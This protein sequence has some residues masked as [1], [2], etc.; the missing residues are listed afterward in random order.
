MKRLFQNYKKFLLFVLLLISRNYTY[1]QAAIQQFWILNQSPETLIWDN[2]G[3]NGQIDNGSGNWNTTETNWT[4]NGGKI[5]TK[6]V[7][8]KNAVFGGNPGVA[9][10]G[11]VTLLN[12]VSVK[13][14]YFK[15]VS[16]GNFILTGSSINSCFSP[17]IISTEINATIASQLTGINPI[18]KTDAGTLTLTGNNT[19]TGSTVVNGGILQCGDG[20]TNNGLSVNTSNININSGST[21]YL[22]YATAVNLSSSNYGPKITGN[23]I[24]RLNS[25]QA[26]N[27]TA[28]WGG[29]ST[30]F[31]SGFTGTLQ[32]DNGRIDGQVP[33]L[34]GIK[35][36]VINENGQFM[37]RTGI[38]S[39]NFSINGNGW[40]ETNY[41][42]AL[43]AA[44]SASPIFTGTITLT[45]DA[46]L[47]IQNSNSSMELQ[48]NIITNGY[49]LGGMIG[50]I[51]GNGGKLILN[52]KNN[53]TFAGILSS[54]GSLTLNG[55]SIITLTG[56]NTYSGGTIINAGTAVAG[57]VN[58]FG[59]GTITVNSGA[60]ISKN[61]FAIAN[62]IINNGGSVLP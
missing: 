12:V 26:V 25:A 57:N 61:G 43:R 45:G 60:T 28:D 2:N 10:A 62:T 37:A 4:G 59:T 8:C 52:T 15:S 36:I 11:I 22:N 29:G 33:G 34:S 16:N 23:G 31:G 18:L 9:V 14:L 48:G 42:G 58:A 20:T 41:T 51:G 5:N 50:G 39:Q 55:S 19:Y 56:N 1:S 47:F 46:N 54:Q 7:S 53:V 44:G 6:W 49:S 38:F 13:G 35:N 24:L 17:M 3:W 32:I 27:G 21:L 40:G 30:V